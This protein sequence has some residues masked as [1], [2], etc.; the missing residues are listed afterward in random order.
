MTK[1]QTIARQCSISIPHTN[2]RKSFLTLSRGITLNIGVK[3]ITESLIKPD[4]NYFMSFTTCLSVFDHF[5]GLALKGLKH[6]R[7]IT[8]TEDL[9]ILERNREITQE[10]IFKPRLKF[11]RTQAN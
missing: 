8:C 7:L 9:I 5:V 6:L 3:Y 4:G 11:S 1:S 2:V 10:N